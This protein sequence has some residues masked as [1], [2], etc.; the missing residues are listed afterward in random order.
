MSDLEELEGVGPSIAKRLRSAG[1]RD[2]RDLAVTPPVEL[3]ERVRGLSRE[4]LEKLASRARVH[5]GLRALTA[6]ELFEKEK[7]TSLLTTGC[8][9]LDELFMGGLEPGITE[10]VGPYGSGKTQI[11]LQLCITVQLPE[12]KGGLS[13]KAFYIDTEGTFSA[14]RV[15]EIAERFGMNVEKALES[16]YVQRAFTSSHQMEAVN[17]AGKFVE[18]N[19]VKLLV[20]DSLTAHFRSEFAGREYLA[21]RQ[22]LLN[23]HIHQLLRLVNKYNLV[24]VVTNQVL[25]VPDAYYGGSPNRPVGGNVVAHGCTFRVWLERKKDLYKATM[26]DSPKHP[27]ESVYFRIDKGGVYEAEED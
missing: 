10:L 3:S 11:C 15:A 6:K 1:V 23:R 24:V 7:K 14:A 4:T 5:L 18:E 21:E 19:G 27:K 20:V 9:T 2:L 25:A 16:I 13:G 8:S 22:F 26:I 12:E 17:L